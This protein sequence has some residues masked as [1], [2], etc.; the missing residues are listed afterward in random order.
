MSAEQVI[1]TDAQAA[2]S[3]LFLWDPW[4]SASASSAHMQISRRCTSVPCFPRRAAQDN[5][6]SLI[7]SV[8]PHI[9]MA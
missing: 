2:S 1:R 3:F 8:R 4:R 6:S 9:G 7:L 5:T